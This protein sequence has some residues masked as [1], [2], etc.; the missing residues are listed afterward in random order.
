MIALV[1][2]FFWCRSHRTFFRSDS[3]I[4]VASMFRRVVLGEKAICCAFGV[5]MTIGFDLVMCPGSI[6]SEGSS[7]GGAPSEGTLDVDVLVRLMT[8]VDFE[9]RLANV[10]ALSS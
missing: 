10:A 4:S 1:V 7:T 9:A 5:F 3:V 6:V 8:G 2:A